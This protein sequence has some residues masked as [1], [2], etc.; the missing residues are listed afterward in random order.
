MR[1]IDADAIPYKRDIVVTERFP[2]FGG[3]NG[4][5]V[6]SVTKEEIDAMPTIDAVTVVRCRDCEHWRKYNDEQFG[7]CMTTIRDTKITRNN[8]YC[9]DGER[10]DGEQM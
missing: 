1:P 4:K 8:D 6:Y 10:K 7:E 5:M 3:F 9:S 2:K